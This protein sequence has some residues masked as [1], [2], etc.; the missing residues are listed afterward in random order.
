MKTGDG[1][2]LIYGSAE[3]LGGESTVAYRLS[4]FSKMAEGS[5]LG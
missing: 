4:P 3:E 1:A 2:F 5:T